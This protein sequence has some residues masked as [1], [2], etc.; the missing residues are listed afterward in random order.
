MKPAGPSIDDLQ[1]TLPLLCL[2]IVL[3]ALPH[4]ANLPLD[5]LG[6][7][8]GACLW[9]IAALHRRVPHPGKAMLLVLTILGGALVYAHFHK[10]HGPEAAASLLL[11]GTGLKVLEV[12]NRRDLYLVVYLAFLIAVTAYLFE[13]GLGMA[14]YTLGVAILLVACLLSMN[15]AGSSPLRVRL[16][17]SALLIGQALPVMLLL[18]LFV[19]RISGPLWRL[20][21]S[22]P[23]AASGLSDS[24]EPGVISRLSLSHATAFRVDFRD[25]P[26]PP[27]ERYW[28]GP[29]FWHFD[30]RTWTAGSGSPARAAKP[31]PAGE[32]PVTAYALTLEPHQRHWVFPLEFAET[33]SHDL[34]FHEDGYLLADEPLR[35]RRRY[36]LT[37]RSQRRPVA[38]SERDRRRA[39]QLPSPPAREIVALVDRF[40]LATSRPEALVRQVLGYFHDE[41]FIYTLQPPAITGDPIA[42]FLFGTR[43]GF[44]EHYAGAFVYLMRVAG[45]PARVVTGYQGGHW[46][47]VGRF[48]EVQQSDA[49]A[50]AEVWLDGRGWVRIDPTT[51]VAPERIERE[52]RFADTAGI[53]GAVLFDGPT[54]AALGERLSN[55]RG[56]LLEAGL[57]WDS[58][59]HAWH[60]W[61]LAYDP[62]RQQRLMQ[63]LGVV[64]WRGLAA[65]LAGIVGVGML[66]LAVALLRQGPTPDRALRIYLRVAR[67]LA[68]AGIV[69]HSAEGWQDFARRVAILRPELAEP[70]GDVTALFTAIR[71]GGSG[72]TAAL[73]RLADAARRF[74]RCC[75]H[76]RHFSGSAAIL[77]AFFWRAGRPHSQGD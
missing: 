62:E 40:R 72:D 31:P 9:R 27:H 25:A 16:R 5:V 29:V 60:R 14:V 15:G 12:S 3:V 20:P 43:R 6:F 34:A 36:E 22:D 1:R 26:P 71:Y 69:R 30:G 56:W 58:I 44:C 67:R 33:A 47:P 48:L 66:W 52:V 49:H 23:A 54:A 10:F 73:Q 21:Q 17:F 76:P 18:F 2:A 64:D 59:D 37:S 75:S 50:W 39:L 74:P 57:V 61:V 32:G 68:R 55:L 45:L 63:K 51:A 11:T 24:M 13:Q 53:D 28:R 70:F 65:W 7:L 77:A 46:N 8:I 42:G 38:L 41:S 4:A 35:E 19:P